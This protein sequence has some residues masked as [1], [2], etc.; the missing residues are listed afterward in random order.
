[1]RSD[2]I[3][4]SC[5]HTKVA[6]ED[7][8]V[9]CHQPCIFAAQRW[10]Q[11]YQSSCKSR[12]KCLQQ[13]RTLQAVRMTSTKV[14]RACCLGLRYEPWLGGGSLCGEPMSSS[15]AMDCTAQ[16][17]RHGLDAHLRCVLC[18][19]Q[20]AVQALAWWRPSV[21]L[22]ELILQNADQHAGQAGLMKQG[23]TG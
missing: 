5:I 20:Y 23:N 11:H 17:I 1:M 9:R 6:A 16:Q 12:R 19:Q 7:H 2:S 3:S 15:C 14:Q 18:R 4:S 22:N 13:V 8:S 21:C 10:A